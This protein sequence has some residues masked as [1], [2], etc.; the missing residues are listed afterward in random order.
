MVSVEEPDVQLEFNVLNASTQ[1]GLA[2]TESPRGPRVVQFFCQ[3]YNGDQVPNLDCVLHGWPP[4]QMHSYSR[5]RQGEDLQ[6][7][8]SASQQII[9]SFFLNVN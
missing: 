8:K 4:I 9:H 6:G 1:P 5:K 7:F 2:H 3:G